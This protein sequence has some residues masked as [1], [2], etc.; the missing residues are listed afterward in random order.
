MS[1]QNVS[2]YHNCTKYTVPLLD[3]Q[4]YSHFFDEKPLKFAT[5]Q[6]GVNIK[7]TSLMMETFINYFKTG[8]VELTTLNAIPLLQLAMQFK[9]SN[10]ETK[11]NLFISN[12]AT[13]FIDTF[14][15]DF[16]LPV[17]NVYIKLIGKHLKFYFD[18]HKIQNLPVST[19]HLILTE[20]IKT[21]WHSKELI[22]FMLNQLDL[23]GEE[24]A[25]LYG[26]INFNTNEGEMLKILCQNYDYVLPYLKKEHMK[27]L[28]QENLKLETVNEELTLE[29][30]HLNL[31]LMKL[32][33]TVKRLSHEILQMKY[34]P[35]KPEESS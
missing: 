12:I 29:N 8:Q 26:L 5:V 7:T 24:A 11:I 16:Q 2:I 20:H 32:G 9:V 21:N 23:K 15:K 3:F 34:E 14:L 35:K 4:K 27:Y 31:E 1:Q 17:E 10:L 19:L 18:N 13:Y 6:Q 22:E 25:P 28:I 33:E 30:G